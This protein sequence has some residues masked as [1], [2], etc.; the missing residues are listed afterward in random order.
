VRRLVARRGGR[1]D[2]DGVLA[3]WWCENDGGEARCFILKD[4]LAGLVRGVVVEGRLWGKEE[5]VRDVLVFCECFDIELRGASSVKPWEAKYFK[6]S[7]SDHFVV[8]T[9]T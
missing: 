9:R 1:V 6:A 2:D 8:L 7:A 3:G 4:K 5:K